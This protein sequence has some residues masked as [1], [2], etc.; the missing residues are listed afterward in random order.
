[1]KSTTNSNHQLND[2]TDPVLNKS[3][4][5]K[6]KVVALLLPALRLYKKPSLRNRYARLK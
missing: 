6:L 1:M 2:T 5:R 4:R 3:I